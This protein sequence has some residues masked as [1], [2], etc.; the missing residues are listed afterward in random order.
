MNTITETLAEFGRSMGMQHLQFRQNG[1]VALGLQSI[2]T[3]GIDVAGEY[4]DAVVV[5]LSRALPNGWEVDG[6]RLLS[7]V[8]HRS[9]HAQRFH[10]GMQQGHVVLAVV[11]PREEF[12]LPK[13][14]D[15]IRQLDRQHQVLEASL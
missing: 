2:G 15:A 11:L 12:T 8:H 1:C 14:H 7:F 9:R 4:Q 3:L 10:L 6:R 5:S 13:L